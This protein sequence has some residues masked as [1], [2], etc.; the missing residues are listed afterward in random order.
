[1]DDVER[2]ER[3][4]QRKRGKEVLKLRECRYVENNIKR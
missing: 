2:T 1:M 4:R 3:R